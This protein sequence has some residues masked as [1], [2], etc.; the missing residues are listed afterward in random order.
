MLLFYLLCVTMF[1]EMGVA[2][3][4][5]LGDVNSFVAARQAAKISAPNHSHHNHDH[6]EH[7][8]EHR[9]RHDEENQWNPRISLP[10]QR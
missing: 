1:D 6:Y 4:L 7:R 3:H 2:I 5:P 9:H 10:L 8:H